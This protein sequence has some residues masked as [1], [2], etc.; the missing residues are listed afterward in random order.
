VPLY[1]LSRPFYCSAI[2]AVDPSTSR[3]ILRLDPAARPRIH[4]DPPL[5]SFPDFATAI[6]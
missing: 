3:P 1:N 5:S 4:R 2:S 6:L